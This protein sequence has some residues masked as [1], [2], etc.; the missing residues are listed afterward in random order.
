MGQPHPVRTRLAQFVRDRRWTEEE[1]C[2]A[3]IAEA[4]RVT[5]SG[6][7]AV[8]TVSTRQ[9]RRW[10][11]GGSGPPRAAACRAL[12]ALFDTP[13][14]VLLGPP[15]APGPVPTGTPD[16]AA[17]A[18]EKDRVA[19]RDTSRP[20]SREEVTMAGD[21]S[22]R[23]WRKSTE[24]NVTDDVL[25]HLWDGVTDLATRY[26]TDP[27]AVVFRD[28]VTARDEIIRLLAGRQAPR[29]TMELHRVAGHLYALLAHASADLDHSRAAAGHARAALHCAEMSGGHNNLI[30]YTRWVMSNIAYWQGR[31][32]EAAAIVDAALPYATTGTSL[33]RLH[34]QR[35]RLHAALGDPAEVP[36]ALT[37]ADHA[38][39]DPG[40]GEPGVFSFSPGK[41]AYYASEA[42][43]G[44]GA[45]TG[46]PRHLRAAVDRATEAVALIEHE[47]R[48]NPQFIAAGRLDLV[49]AHLAHGDL[50]VVAERLCPVLSIPPAQRTIPVITRART[51]HDLLT[52]RAEKSPVMTGPRDDLAGFCVQP[53][54]TDQET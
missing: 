32:D 49:R 39:T 48:P 50:D 19:R 36:R 12:E 35:A 10:M 26:T 34:S 54:T 52:A 7:Q 18:G 1:F 25:E 16:T 4:G 31:H 6:R 42:H 14:E 2:Q 3:V 15:G 44:A 8:I 9:A 24:T 13:V 30:V 20:P 38:P 23:W 41:A 5:V 28:L 33:L 53:A 17:G 45:V 21:D 43:R 40:P 27:P 29:Q 47:P 37:A 11:A 51:L 46:D 22:V